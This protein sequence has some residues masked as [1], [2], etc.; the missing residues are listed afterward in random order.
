[1]I[2]NVRGYLQSR[3]VF[4]LA[5]IHTHPRK[6][7]FARPGPSIVE[8]SYISDSDLSAQGWEY[9]DALFTAVSH[10]KAEIDD[11]RLQEAIDHPR[12]R[13]ASAS[14]PT[15]P[16]TALSPG[17]ARLQ[18]LAVWTS[19]RRRCHHTGW[20]FKRAHKVVEMP[21]LSELNPG[22]LDGL[23]AERIERDHP[24][25]WR[26]MLANPFAFVISSFQKL[27]YPTP[28]QVPCTPR[29]KLL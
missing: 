14:R 5:N 16:V 15:T 6:I 28:G 27:K 22:D 13:S 18:R 23:T 19:T 10:R 2:K 7:F 4:L 21:Q 1:M 17:H 11:E 9:A 20:P 8:H 26:D 24:D 3:I 25:L 29:R 12:A